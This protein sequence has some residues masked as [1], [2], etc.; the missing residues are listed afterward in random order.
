MMFI[1]LYDRVLILPQDTE[2]EIEGFK[3]PDATKQDHR[4]GSIVAVGE[5][6]VSEQGEVRPLR[7]KIGDT[8]LFHPYAGIP[9]VIDGSEFLVMREGECA[10]KLI[11]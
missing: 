10:G 11:S 7:L 5:G 2:R 1:P 9:M 6:Y 3:I 8:V 4:I